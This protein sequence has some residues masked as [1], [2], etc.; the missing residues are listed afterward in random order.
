M[1]PKSRIIE[2]QQYAYRI[3]CA[4]CWTGSSRKLVDMIMELLAER[5]ELLRDQSHEAFTAQAKATEA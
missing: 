2:I 3:A 4:N 5:E 1:L